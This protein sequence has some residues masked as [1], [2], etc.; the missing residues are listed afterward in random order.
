M[1]R[2]VLY[3]L[4]PYSDC[5]VAP[6]ASANGCPQKSFWPLGEPTIGQYPRIMRAHILITSYSLSKRVLC[7]IPIVRWGFPSTTSNAPASTKVPTIQLNSATLHL[8]IASDPTG[9]L[10]D[11]P[12]TTALCFR[13]QS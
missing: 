10:R 12:H 2:Y 3:L 5:A 9:R 6:H 4:M 13:C 11:P 7:S 8:E 1:I